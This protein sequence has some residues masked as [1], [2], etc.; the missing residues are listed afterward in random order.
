MFTTEENCD[1]ADLRIAE[2]LEGKDSVTCF[3]SREFEGSFHT[4]K[5]RSNV[6]EMSVGVLRLLC[7]EDTEEGDVLK[8]GE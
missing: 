7:F 2:G 1:S 8:G 4:K 6:D 5:E 3:R